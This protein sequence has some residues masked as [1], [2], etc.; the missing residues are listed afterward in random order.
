MAAKKNGHFIA[1]GWSDDGYWAS[2]GVYNTSQEAQDE[3]SNNHSGL[4][5]IKVISLLGMSEKVKAE[6]VPVLEM[7]FD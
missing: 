5:Q 3:L 1:V 6:D 2:A 4:S 7:Y